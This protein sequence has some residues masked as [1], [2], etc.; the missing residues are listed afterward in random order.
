MA[1]TLS[2]TTHDDEE[3]ARILKDFQV[4]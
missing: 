1:N 4:E 2:K 3:R